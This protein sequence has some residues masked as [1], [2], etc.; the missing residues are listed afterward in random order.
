MAKVSKKKANKRSSKAEKKR[1][2]EE[3][4][5]RGA[6]GE[7]EEV[8]GAGGEEEEEEEV[9]GAG[10]EEEEEEVKGAGGAV[11]SEEE[12]GED[13]EDDRKR[14]RLLEAIMALGGKR[15]KTLGERSEAAALMSEFTVTAEGEAERVELSDLVGAAGGAP[16]VPAQSRKQLRSLQRSQRTE[17]CPL[18]SQQRERIQRDLAFQKTAA[19]VSRWDA[20]ISQNQRAEQLVFP[21]DREPSGPRP[22]ERVVV[23]WGAQTPLEREVFA[24]LSAHKQP[25]HD[26]VLTPAEEASVRA[27]SLEEAR[28]RRAELQKARALQSYHEAKARREA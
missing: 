26:P 19:R 20:V 8:R 10:G 4:E 5:V 27:M 24:L 13:G 14:R 7:E 11:S 23:G 15:K 16:A 1:L 25:L 18:S 12:D 22:M 9:N 21:L 28:V 3:E 6:G 2:M 17:E